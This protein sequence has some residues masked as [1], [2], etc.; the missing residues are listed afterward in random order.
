MKPKII[1]IP[2]NGGSHI[3]TDNWYAW[4]RDTLRGKGYEVIAEDMPDPIAAH[5]NI[6]L[7]HIENVFNADANTIIIGHSSG[8]VAA[9]RYLETHKL[10]GAIIVGAMYTDL[11]F[12]DEKASGYYDLPWQWE[13]I[14]INA[15]WIAQFASADDPYI[16]VDQP[17]FIH[18]QLDSEYFELDGRGHYMIEQN[19]LNYT[20]PEIIDLIEQKM[21][22]NE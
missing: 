12:E 2:G 22:S 17:R 3:E 9:L 21:A 19:P 4:L 5:A 13:K 11:G 8:G 16:P 18:D 6:W 7:P 20:F 14:K 15:R 1:I 10:L